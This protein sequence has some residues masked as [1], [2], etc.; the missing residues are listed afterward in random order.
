MIRAAV[1]ARGVRD[2]SRHETAALSV[3]SNFC[4]NC[5]TPTRRMYSCRF[6]EP[7]NNTFRVNTQ[8]ESDTIRLLSI[9][10]GGLHNLC[11]SKKRKKAPK[12]DSETQKTTPEGIANG[13]RL[14]RLREAK[15]LSRAELELLTGG[16]LGG[17]RI[18][19]Y[20]AGT[21][22]LGVVEA[23]ILGAALGV[24]PAYLMGLVGTEDA[25]F[26]TYPDDAR[27]AAMRALKAMQPGQKG[28]V[29][30]T[31]PSKTGTY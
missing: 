30:S 18:G 25:E 14:R 13:A 29:N 17:S 23:R 22:M 26:L 31:P 9:V 8:C 15:G 2:P 11:M 28:A 4:A 5:F 1:R 16:K 7:V 6:M 27:F 24:H 21:R 3:T 19:N 20:E 12:P 10:L